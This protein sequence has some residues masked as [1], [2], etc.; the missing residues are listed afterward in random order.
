[1]RYGLGIDTG[2]TYTDAVIYDFDFNKV[3]C[4]AK[5]ITVK[6]DLTIGIN[7]AI[8]QLLPETLDNVQL[9]SLSTTLATNACVEGKGSRA[10]LVLI[11]CDET[12][13][14]RYGREYGLPERSSIIFL[15]GGHN[16][17]GEVAG[18]PEWDAL[19]ADITDCAANTDV[20]AVVE[21]WGIRNPEFEMKAKELIISWTG[22]PVVCGYELTGEINSLKRAASALLNAQLIPIINEFFNA[23]KI[24]L[25][26]K[27]IKAPLVI[28]RGD[29]SLM[30]E[31]FARGK[32][33][34]T[35]LCGPAAS[36][37]GGISL[38]GEKNCVIIDMGG[39]T[40]DIAI[41]RDGIPKLAVEGADIGMWRTG[42]KS[43]MIHTVG[44]GGDSLIRHNYQNTLNIGPVRAAPLSWTASSWPGILDKIKEIYDNKK[45]HSVSLCEFFYLI[46]DIKDDPFYYS[47][48]KAI[49]NALRNGPLSITELAQVVDSSVYDLKTARLEQYGVI[50]RCGLTP[51]D[52]MHLT[53]AFTGWKMDAAYYGARIMANQIDV[54]LDSM[55]E[56]INE[57]VKEKLYFNIVQMLIEDE[58]EQSL[59][60]GM[61]DQLKS[62]IVKAFKKKRDM[63]VNGAADIDFMDCGFSTDAVLVGIGAPI[64]IY[65][66]DVAAALGTKCVVPENAGV[67][68]A[69][70]AITGNVLVEERILIRPVYSMSGITGFLAFS[71]SGNMEFE[72]HHDAVAWAKKMAY[73]IALFSAK[74]RGAESPEIKVSVHNNE[75]EIG[76]ADEG[77][78]AGKGVEVPAK[79]GDIGVNEEDIKDNTLLLETVVMA[80]ATGK[81][82]YSA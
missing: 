41:A 70:G 76:M 39:T 14:E 56:M 61:S 63:L 50:M 21:L 1:M 27:G 57:K 22:I 71:T 19:K 17:D 10:K 26:E 38:T 74:E 79:Q 34:E 48:E 6:E 46:R 60:G 3:I 65:L 15:S 25:K 69:I 45:K 5:S 24:S 72:E 36:I 4:T 54:S 77:D 11:G 32:P 49:A 47:S 82:S 55:I 53:G 66:P 78:D 73:D 44:L 7:G 31:E 29:G 64:H 18:E 2:G 42:I 30:S 75:F 35:L 62:L 28:V 52:I 20:F 43:I 67:A 59:S 58:D 51:T 8:D 23:V 13:A 16:H 12:V 81:I 37:A 68:N 40:S 33:V 80:R 9:V